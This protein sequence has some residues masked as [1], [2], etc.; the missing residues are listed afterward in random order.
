MRTVNS[1]TLWTLI[2]LVLL[3]LMALSA[4]PCFASLLWSG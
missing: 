1:R 2:I 3:I 4:Q